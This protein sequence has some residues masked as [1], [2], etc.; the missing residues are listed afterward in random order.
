M[1]KIKVFA[2]KE[3]QNELAN[4]LKIQA[5]YDAFVVGEA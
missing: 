4:L 3:R 1:V 5:S 2:P